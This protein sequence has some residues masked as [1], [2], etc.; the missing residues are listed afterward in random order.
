MS[1]RHE[2][3]MTTI[4]LY[5]EKGDSLSLDAVAQGA[6]CSKTLIVHYFGTRAN[7]LRSC[8]KMVCEEVTSALDA[9]ELPSGTDKEALKQYLTVLWKVY[10][11]YLKDNPLKARFYI[12]YTHSPANLPPQYKT[13]EGMIMSA[14]NENFQHLVEDDPHIMFD[15][16]YMVAMA[17]GMAAFVFSEKTVPTEELTER[18]SHIMMN[19]VVSV[20][21]GS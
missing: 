17:N 5:H 6:D 8:F 2:I 14:L 18:C 19:G 4:K 16:E 20:N 13:P 1:K 15:I 21:R 10:F 7:L 9:A 12:E 11:N 3:M